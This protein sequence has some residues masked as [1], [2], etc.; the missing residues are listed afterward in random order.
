MIMKKY[1]VFLI[2]LILAACAPSPQAGAVLSSN[3]FVRIA[4]ADDQSIC[5]GG[6]CESYQLD[7]DGLGAGVFPNGTL[8]L[9]ITPE[10]IAKKLGLTLTDHSPSEGG[11]VPIPGKVG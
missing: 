9:S 1:A 8:L 4:A 2:A 7:S 11:W 5:K 6:K 10:L 3:G